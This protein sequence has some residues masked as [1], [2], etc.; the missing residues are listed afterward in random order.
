MIVL[1]DRIADYLLADTPTPLALLLRLPVLTAVAFCLLW[2]VA[3]G[4]LRAL[5]VGLSPIARLAAHALWYVLLWPEAR[6]SSQAAKRSR[7]PAT[8]LYVYG[9]QVECLAIAT[10]TALGY[11]A[12]MLVAVSRVPSSILVVASLGWA[13]TCLLT[14]WRT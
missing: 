4:I 14:G 8:A 13:A 9:D 12:R 10:R 1:L 6:L 7:P 5:A 3:R 11:L 2:T